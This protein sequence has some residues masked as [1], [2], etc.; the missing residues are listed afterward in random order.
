[1][2]SQIKHYEWSSINKVSSC[3]PILRAF[4]YVSLHTEMSPSYAI[5]YRIYA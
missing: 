3:E 4:Q 1:L 5:I 2:L